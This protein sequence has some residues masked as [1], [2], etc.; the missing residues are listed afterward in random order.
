[1]AANLELVAEA[2]AGLAAL[3]DPV[4]AA[5]QQAYMKS[6]MPYR[7]LVNADMRRV[8]RAAIE[9]HPL[10]GHAAWRA[11]I[12]EL[13]RGAGYR[14]ERY[15]A[16]ELAGHR[17]YRQHQLMRTLPMYEELVVTGAWWD[18]VDTI[19][20][21]RLGPMLL[22]MP[23]EMSAAMLGWS[24]DP[25]PWKRRSSIICQVQARGRTDPDLLTACIE[26]SIDDRGFF[27]RK[28]IGWSLREY[29]KVEPRW[30][31]AFV[32][33]REDRLSGLSRREALKHLGP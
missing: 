18:Y 29:A 15:V 33:E 16:L 11:T 14:E 27:L 5:G 6:A 3:A 1:M 21:H 10:P 28:A 31:A 4:R 26:P 25:D 19:A 17:L 2:R 12:L 13:W 9:A 8:A 22:A 24:R 23:I 20:V 32:K 30:V 7:G